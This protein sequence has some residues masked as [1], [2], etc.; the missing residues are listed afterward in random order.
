MFQ[1][2]HQWCCIVGQ[3]MHGLMYSQL[4]GRGARNADLT[5]ACQLLYNPG[6]VK[7]ADADSL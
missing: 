4:A 7:E 1:M 6:E 2:S 5:C 3:Q